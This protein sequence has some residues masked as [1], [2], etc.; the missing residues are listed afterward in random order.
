MRDLRARLAEREAQGLRRRL[1]VRSTP[2]GPE[3]AVDGRRLLA[4]CSNDYLGLAGHPALSRALCEGAERFGA[5]SGAA[6]LLG[7]HSAA[8]QALEEA[9]ADFTGRRRVLL[10]A[11]GYAANL[12]VI[13]ALAER[14]EPVFHDRLNHASLLDGTVLARAR[15]V[16]YAHG[17][18]ADLARRLQGQ[19]ARLVVTDGVFSMDGDLA[20]L[21]ALAQATARA[22]GVLMVDDAHG[23]GVLGP[24][25]RGTLARFGLGLSEVPIL[26]GTFGKAFGTAGAFVAGSETLIEGLVHFG[27]PW[28]YSTAPAPALAHATR[29]ALE[30]VRGAEA[31]RARLAELVARFR[32]GAAELGLPLAASETP[33]QPLLLGGADRAQAVS[34]ALFDAGFWVPAIRPPTVPAGSAR[35]RITLSAAHR[36]AQVD[37][38]L[39]A[40]EVVLRRH[41]EEGG[42]P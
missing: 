9:L 17:D 27:R 29:R 23:L 7:G 24:Q 13:S 22:G 38:L 31:E 32:R 6:H 28:I 15:V 5:G 26:V 18:A 2:Q 41:P 10:F 25:G 35:L 20:P 1:R 4:F 11:S 33:I 12:A 8:H 36:E 34:S 30:L 3:V 16:R 42:T 37:R 21:P 19:G 40:L 14:G 39:E